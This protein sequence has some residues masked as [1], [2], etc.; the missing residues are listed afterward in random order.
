[1]HFR[2]EGCAPPGSK[3]IFPAPNTSPFL[4]VQRLAWVI[5]GRCLL[6]LR[7][8][9]NAH[10][11]QLINCVNLRGEGPQFLRLC[12]LQHD[13]TIFVSLAFTVPTTKCPNPPRMRSMQIHLDTTISRGGTISLLMRWF[14]LMRPDADIARRLRGVTD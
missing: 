8:H 3:K 4:R 9:L 6:N 10:G 14:Q 13:P 11:V 5:S 7:G 1:M 12:R 2:L